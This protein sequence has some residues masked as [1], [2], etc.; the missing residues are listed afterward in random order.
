[1]AKILIVEDDL[2]LVETYTD[3]LELN[4]HRVTS[5]TRANEAISVMTRFRPD[6]VLLDLNLADYS[7]TIVVTMIRKVAFLRNT[8]IVV[9]TGHPE[10]I[11]NTA[12]S[13]QVDLILNKPISNDRLLETVS[14][15]AVQES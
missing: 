3:L 5:V 8:R 10:M 15:F 9:V 13:K 14:H 7:G 11:L 4:H 2:D 6:V 12:S 1:M